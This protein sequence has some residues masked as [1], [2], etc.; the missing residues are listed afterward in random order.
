MIVIDVGCAR[1]GDI[2]SLERLSVLFRPDQLY[3][4]DPVETEHPGT[5]NTTILKVAAWL[6][7]GEI[8]FQRNGTQSQ[9]VFGGEFERVPCIDL[10]RFINQFSGDIILKMDAEGAEWVLLPHLMQ[11]GADKRLVLALVEWHGNDDPERER[12]EDEFACPIEEW[13]W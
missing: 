5:P 3:G 10:V 8:N 6:W 7:D 13:R 9:T 12:I 2:Y 4:M 1:Y 11:H